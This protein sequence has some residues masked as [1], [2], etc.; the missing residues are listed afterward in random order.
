MEASGIPGLT[1]EGEQTRAQIEKGKTM[2]PSPGLNSLDNLNTP[3]NSKSFL[4]GDQAQALCYAQSRERT[5]ILNSALGLALRIME[6]IPKN[7]GD[8]RLSGLTV[9]SNSTSQTVGRG[10]DQRRIHP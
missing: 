3:D 7:S 10:H 6:S 9:L 4:L 1:N 5:L 2:N 8:E